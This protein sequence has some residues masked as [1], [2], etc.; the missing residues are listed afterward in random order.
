MALVKKLIATVCAIGLIF[1]SAFM[2]YQID[3]RQNIS[4][5][6]VEVTENE[7]PTTQPRA[8]SGIDLSKY[9]TANLFSSQSAIPYTN[10][11]YEN[12]VVKQIS[13]DSADYYT[14]KIQFFKDSTLLTQSDVIFPQTGT[15]PALTIEKPSEANRLFFGLNGREKDTL[16]MIDVSNFPNGKY[17]ATWNVLNI[18]QGSVSWDNI[19]LNSGEVAYPYIPNLDDVY[20]DG[21]NKG[22]SAGHEA[23]YQEG[24]EDAS[25]TLNLG[26]FFGATVSGSF[27]YQEGEKLSLSDGT[28]N[29]LY[30]SVNFNSIWKKYEV[31]PGS[32]GI[33]NLLETAEI[34]LNFKTTF[35][36]YAF[37]LY[38][39]GDSVVTSA[40]FISSDGSRY[41][42]SIEKWDSNTSIGGE[43]ALIKITDSDIPSSIEVTAL[44]IYFGRASDT[45]QNATVYSNAGGYLNG[46]DNGYTAGNSAGHTEG[47]LQGREEGYKKGEKVGY[48]NGYGVGYSD[49]LKTAETGDFMSLI[50]AVIDAPVTA[51]TS[52]LDFEILGF[53]MRTFVLSILTAALVIA[54][55]RLFSGKFG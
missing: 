38:F 17:T 23:G 45:L 15:I 5:S 50:T 3:N 13:A 51:F 26:I 19:M 53:N 24:Y 2:G 48:E 33:Y 18:T 39:S 40:T 10:C 46:Y 55:L 27:T 41:K 28:P 35:D 4:A 44:T 20:N 29:F 6:A 1:A 30:N 22:E 42:A 32:S 16:I 9:P 14:W 8:S 7:V 37:S 54:M 12:G 11:T 49:G 34:T 36:Y 43:Y 52:L 31:Y 47:V 21:Y 25:D